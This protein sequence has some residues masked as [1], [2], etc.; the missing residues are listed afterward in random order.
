MQLKT[1][2]EKPPIFVTHGLCGTVQ[3]SELAKHVRTGHPIYGIQGKGI[4]DMG[5]PFE[6]VED[7]AGFYLQALEEHTPDRLLLRWFGGPGNGATPVRNWK[8]S[9][10]AGAAGY[11][12]A[13]TLFDGDPA[14]AFG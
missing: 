3:F 13:S 10:V 8:E 2:S 9:S 7:M 14:P 1:G 12:S 6:H 11:I 4:D 5:E